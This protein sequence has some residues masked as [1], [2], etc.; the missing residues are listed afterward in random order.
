MR[1][2]DPAHLGPLK[3]N[4]FL[5]LLCCCCLLLLLFVDDGETT[6]HFIDFD[7]NLK[8]LCGNKRISKWM[9]WKFFKGRNLTYHVGNLSKGILL[10]FSFFFSSSCCYSFFIDLVF[11]WMKFSAQAEISCSGFIWRLFLVLL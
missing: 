6:E 3:I 4:K 11:I 2:L 7:L 10:W 5:F 9:K 1:G 8:E